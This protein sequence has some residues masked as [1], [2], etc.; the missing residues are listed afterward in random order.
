[1]LDDRPVGLAVTRRRFPPRAYV[2][3][4]DRGKIFALEYNPSVF[5]VVDTIL[6]R[7]GANFIALSPDELTAY[8]S[9][10]NDRVMVV[11]L[12]QGFV[13]REIPVG[14]EPLGLDVSPD[15]RYVLVANSASDSVSLIE[16][17]RRIVIDEIPVGLLPT[18]A[19][20]VSNTRAYVALQG[21]NA[22]AVVDIVRTP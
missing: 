5:A 21:E 18:D 6:T 19:L 20:F 7:A 9:G 12:D 4:L 11:G 22:L 8:I 13:E 14:G 16:T 17:D 1:V 10:G 2:V 3:G 15:G